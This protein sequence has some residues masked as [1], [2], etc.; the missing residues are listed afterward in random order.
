MTQR[1][2]EIRAQN[3]IDAF[4]HKFKHVLNL[5]SISHKYHFESLETW[6][7]ELIFYHC[8]TN[9]DGKNPVLD[10]P[11]IRDRDLELMLRVSTRI[12]C[13]TFSGAAE[14]ALMNRLKGRFDRDFF[15]RNLALA[16]ELGIRKFQGRLYYNEL[17]RQESL[18][19]GIQLS[20]TSIYSDLTE[21]QLF[22]LFRGYWSLTCYWKNLPS[23]VRNKPLPSI[24][25]CAAH[26]RCQTL[27][28]DKWSADNLR[29]IV[30]PSP[31]LPLEKLEKIRPL[32]ISPR[33]VSL[34]F[35]V[36]IQPCGLRELDEITKQLQGT[37]ADHFLGPGR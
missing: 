1:P 33:D 25:A 19:T 28:N 22:A 2:L 16:E 26:G 20:T 6:A 11:R 10:S 18:Q 5:L 15:I 13:Y 9:A 21:K 17:L 37:L 34:G 4:I 14:N 12:N 7:K 29:L 8:T 36:K 31:P 32:L 23:L 35:G 3:R 27:W 30:D 24:A